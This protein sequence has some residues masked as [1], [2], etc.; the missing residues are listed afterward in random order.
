[1]KATLKRLL[2]RLGLARLLHRARNRDVLTVAMFHRVLPTDDPRFAGANPTYT[3]SLAEFETCLDFFARFYSVVGLEDLDRKPWPSC[4]LLIT[5]DDGWRDTFEF[6]LP[7]LRARGFP[8]VLFVATD[9]IGDETGFWQERVYDHLARQGA[10][11]TADARIAT[12]ATLPE[13]AR[14]VE[15]DGLPAPA[16]PRR[17]AD[18]DELAA[19]QR[20]GIA[21]GGHGMTH[22]PLTEVSDAAAE[23]AGCRTRLAELGL[24]GTSPAFSFPHG[25]VT[26]ALVAEARAAGFG[27]CFTSAQHLVSRAGLDSPAGIGRLSIELAAL[28]HAGGFDLAALAFS[29]IMRPHRAG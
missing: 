15:L 13:A 17:M 23:L 21:I 26:P 7:A 4:P 3:L 6:A 25:R 11:A 27:R 14:T 19:M 29:L 12:L 5:F 28:R 10:A 18:V 22:R 1:M 9:F 16:L 24:G 20:A 8:A 2:F